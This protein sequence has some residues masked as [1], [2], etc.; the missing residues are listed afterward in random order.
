MANN[1]VYHLTVKQKES[2]R[3]GEDQQQM[4]K[5]TMDIMGGG[6]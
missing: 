1:Q 2:V 5:Y 6:C 3:E 4:Y